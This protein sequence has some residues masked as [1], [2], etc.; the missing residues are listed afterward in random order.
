MANPSALED[1]LL[2][3]YGLDASEIPRKSRR[4][5][6][7]FTVVRNGEVIGTFAELRKIFGKER[8]GWD[9][10]TAKEKGFP[11]RQDEFSRGLGSDRPDLGGRY[12]KDNDG[13]GL[14]GRMV[15]IGIKQSGSFSFSLLCIDHSV[16]WTWNNKFRKRRTLS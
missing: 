8:A 12:G 2:E 4:T 11:P 15:R 13:F 10:K 3:H 16:E 14:A 1:I 5:W 6:D 7:A 9:E